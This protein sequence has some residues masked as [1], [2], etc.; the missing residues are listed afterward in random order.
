MIGYLY[1]VQGIVR[2]FG[3]FHG[4]FLAYVL[5]LI[6]QFIQGIRRGMREASV[7]AVSHK[8]P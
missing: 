2:V 1:F 4:L 5:D 6:Y 7:E 8:S 3:L